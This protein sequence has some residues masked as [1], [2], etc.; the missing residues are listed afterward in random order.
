[1]LA[2]QLEGWTAVGQAGICEN[3]DAAAERSSMCAPRPQFVSYVF[4]VLILLSRRLL[5][6]LFFSHSKFLAVCGVGM[7]SRSCL[8]LA[9]N[10]IVSIP[11][12]FEMWVC[13][14]AQKQAWASCEYLSTVRICNWPALD[15]TLWACSKN[16][17]RQPYSSVGSGLDRIQ[18]PCILPVACNMERFVKST[19]ADLQRYLHRVQDLSLECPDGWLQQNG[20]CYAPALDLPDSSCEVVVC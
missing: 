3:H 8:Y 2:Y 10:E 12:C 17:L 11:S 16:F 14:V 4:H 15:A 6:K 19:L 9:S 1:M 20:L 18:W 5:L 13:Q 7:M